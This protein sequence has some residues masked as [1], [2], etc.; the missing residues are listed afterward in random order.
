MGEATGD[1]EQARYT[2]PFSTADV[3]CAMLWIVL[4]G[5]GVETA[6][7]MFDMLHARLALLLLPCDLNIC[8]CNMLTL[9][10]LLFGLA[11]RKLNVMRASTM[12]RPRKWW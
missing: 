11:Y 9:A 8:L 7:Q 1:N 4:R 2:E 6:A 5:V 12:A 10:L 3:L